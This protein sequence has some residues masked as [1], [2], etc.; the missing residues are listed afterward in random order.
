MHEEL[1]SLPPKWESRSKQIHPSDERWQ[2]FRSALDRINVW[3][4]HPEYFE[5]VCDGTGWSAAI[6]YPD[7]EIV[8]GGSNCFPGE[9]GKPVSI[10]DRAKGDTFDQF[11][12]A[13]S[14]L[15]R[16]RFQ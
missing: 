8:S 12:R 15:L 16:R 13:V 2:A 4:W 10:V 9:P 3:C 14:S 7:K 6:T 11:C 5:P 1:E